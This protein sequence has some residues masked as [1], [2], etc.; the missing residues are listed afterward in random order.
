MVAQ[1]PLLCHFIEF[2]PTDVFSRTVLCVPT[3]PYFC[4]L[5]KAS[6]KA[7]L[8]VAAQLLDLLFVAV[9]KGDIRYLMDIYIGTQCCSLYM[10]AMLQLHALS[11]ALNDR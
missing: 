4:A 2:I 6:H 9:R 5:V 1:C 3:D 11:C 10:H 7:V 8:S